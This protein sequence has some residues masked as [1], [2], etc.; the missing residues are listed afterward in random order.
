M[1]EAEGPTKWQD[2]RAERWHDKRMREKGYNLGNKKSMN[3]LS[4]EASQTRKT[5]SKKGRTI[6]SHLHF[7][8]WCDHT[9]MTKDTLQAKYGGV[10]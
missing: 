2:R 3:S 6:T 7:V 5:S 8:I 9:P 10:S 1:S 4:C